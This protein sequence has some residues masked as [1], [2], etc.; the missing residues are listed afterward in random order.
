MSSYLW[1]K[2]IIQVTQSDECQNVASTEFR[3][4]GPESE[5][6]NPS[7]EFENPSS[8]LKTQVWVWKPE[9]RAWK[10]ESEGKEYKDMYEIVKNLLAYPQTGLG[11]LML[12]RQHP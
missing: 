9:F 6:E 5:S 7:Y 8:S 4:W 3:V 2:I 12:L 1:N 11:E 10:P